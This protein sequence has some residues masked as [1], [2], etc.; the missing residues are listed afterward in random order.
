[1]RRERTSLPMVARS[2]WSQPDP[3][4]GAIQQTE[5]P[6]KL[7]SSWGRAHSPGGMASHRPVDQGTRP[8]QSKRSLLPRMQYT[9]LLPN[10]PGLVYWTLDSPPLQCIQI[11]LS[12]C[13]AGLSLPFRELNPWLKVIYKYACCKFLNWSKCL[14]MKINLISLLKKQQRSSVKTHNTSNI[15]YF[16]TTMVSRFEKQEWSKGRENILG[17][18]KIYSG[19]RKFSR[20]K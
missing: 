14:I 9:G 13:L 5:N 1:M 7:L 3:K 19:K 6:P 18:W 11:K 20:H 17:I 8:C 15:K 2:N 12:C 16:C 10:P 4:V